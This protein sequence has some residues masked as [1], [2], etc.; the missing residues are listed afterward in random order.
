MTR[1]LLVAMLLTQADGVRPR[2]GVDK[3][4]R[5]RVYL[6]VQLGIKIEGPDTL[7][8][9]VRSM[10]PLLSMEKLVLRAEGGQQIPSR[11]KRKVD[12]DEARVEMRYDDQDYEYDY[13][14]GAPAVG[15]Q[16]KILQMM[17]F[18]AMAGRSYNLSAEG[19]YRSDDATQ[20]HN[21]EAMD[22]YALGITR[23]PDGPVKEGGTYEKSWKG[24]RS[25]KGKKGRWDFVQ[26][27]TVEKVEEREGK[28]VAVLASDLTGTLNG[29]DPNPA[30]EESWTKCEGKTRVTI[31]LEGGRVLASEGEGLITVYFRNT[32]ESGQRQELRLLFAAQGKSMIK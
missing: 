17:V 15:D 9:L 10:H 6:E 23:M 3:S 14:K 31:E 30:A 20:D 16:D 29:A 21:G 22:L 25:E 19:E 12:Y 8:S 27:V 32:S 26:K 2:Y 18:L 1:L 13:A 5:E 4:S 7:A 24:S 28:A 11:G